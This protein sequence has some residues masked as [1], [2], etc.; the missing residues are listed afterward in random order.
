[1]TARLRRRPQ[2]GLDRLQLRQPRLARRRLDRHAR[3]RRQRDDPLPDGQ[4]GPVV[5]PLPH[6]LPPRG[7]LRRRLGR[8][9]ARRERGEP[10]APGVVRPLPD[11]QRA[12]G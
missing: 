2:R 6:R 1:M 9:L 11:V 12:L 5:P 4:P 8:G 7:R 10:R 3:G